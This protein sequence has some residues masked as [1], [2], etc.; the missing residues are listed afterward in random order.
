L[1]KVD[2]ES[3]L[4]PGFRVDAVPLHEGDNI[5]QL[6][7]D[8]ASHLVIRKA[9]TPVALIG[10]SLKFAAGEFFDFQWR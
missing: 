10:E 2:I 9:D 8:T 1:M 5:G 4:P 7:A 3:S 6:V